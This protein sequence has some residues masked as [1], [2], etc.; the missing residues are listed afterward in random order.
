MA[1]SSLGQFQLWVAATAPVALCNSRALAA[2]E[3]GWGP[4]GEEATLEV[5]TVD[6]TGHERWS[7]FW[8]VTLAGK[9]YLRLGNHGAERIQGNHTNPFV[10]V[11]LGRQR[12]DDVRVVP[13]PE[14]AGQVAAAM[15]KKY[16][17]DLLIRWLPHPLTV[18]L[19]RGV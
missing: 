9:I 14:M 13:A 7:K 4:L 18:R 5:L 6:Q 19:E 17:S 16:P 10:S 2:R 11:K 3:Q 15:A 1:R 12:F 8:W